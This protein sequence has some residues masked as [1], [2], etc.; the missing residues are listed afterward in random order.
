LI[1]GEYDGIKQIHPTNA[2]GFGE[3]VYFYRYEAE[4]DFGD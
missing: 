4:G 2:K 1:E 3:I